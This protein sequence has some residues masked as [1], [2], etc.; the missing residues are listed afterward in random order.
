M[1][2]AGGLANASGSFG[3]S[4]SDIIQNQGNAQ[5]AGQVGS[6]NAWGNALGNIADF[7]QSIPYMRRML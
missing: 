6:G 3:R 4:G 7:G 1:G 2:A 5:A